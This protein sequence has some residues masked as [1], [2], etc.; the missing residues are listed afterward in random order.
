MPKHLAIA[1][2]LQLTEPVSGSARAEGDDPISFRGWL[3][4]HSALEAIC[5]VALSEMT[6]AP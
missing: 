2:D 4:L 3:Q 5:A 6:P 1:I